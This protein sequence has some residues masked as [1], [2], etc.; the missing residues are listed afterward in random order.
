MKYIKLENQNKELV[1]DDINSPI[2][3]WD[4]N[5]MD[6]YD[7][8]RLFNNRYNISYNNKNT[9]KVKNYRKSNNQNSNNVNKS[10]Y[11][12]INHNKINQYHKNQSYKNQD[13][14]GLNSNNNK[15]EIFD[16]KNKKVHKKVNSKLNKYKINNIS[17]FGSYI[18]HILNGPRGM[19]FE[20]QDQSKRKY[21]KI[22]HLEYKDSNVSYYNNYE[23][24]FDRI[25]I[26]HEK[27]NDS[28]PNNSKILF[29][30]LENDEYGNHFHIF[31]GYAHGN[32]VTKDGHMHYMEG[33]TSISK[34]H[35]HKFRLYTFLVLPIKD[36]NE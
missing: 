9:N 4:T 20:I 18:D 5:R 25:F 19:V 29:Q 23:P 21:I 35:K 1:C 22:P 27:N 16:I 13:T 24:V 15:N 2:H 17:I 34:G 26:N 12:K 11:Y 8:N 3:S 6:S 28:I 30:I 33:E 10:N 31:K 7:E 32:I 14:N 36:E